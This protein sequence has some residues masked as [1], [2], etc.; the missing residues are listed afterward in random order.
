MKNDF[1]FRKANIKDLKEILRLNLKLFK[2]EYKNFDK[3]LN[4]NWTYKNAEYFKN[5]I[6]KN[7]G[8]VEVVESK[9]KIIGYL[10]GGT[11]ALEG[12]DYRKKAKYAELENMLIEKIFRSKGLGA[13]LVKHFISWCEKNKIDCLSVIASAENK[14]TIEFYRKLGFENYDLILEMNINK[15]PVRRNKKC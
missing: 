3:S 15:K 6:I 13:K 14:P 5:R 9:E 12:L 1:I 10:C 2:E 8:F 4:L 11:R 7:D